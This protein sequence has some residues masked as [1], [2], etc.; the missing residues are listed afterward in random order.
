M[1]QSTGVI[2]AVGGITFLNKWIG[3]DQGIDLRIP[4]ATGIAALMLDLFEKASVGLATGIAWI[5]L[6]TS[7]LIQPASGQSAISNLLRLTGQQ[8]A[9]RK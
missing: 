4:V 2:L 3:N 5:A 9:V 7:L 8:T 6:V 1:G